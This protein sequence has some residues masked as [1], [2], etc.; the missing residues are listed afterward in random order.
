MS[1]IVDVSITDKG[2]R[3]GSQPKHGPWGGKNADTLSNPQAARV[4]PPTRDIKARPKEITDE[5]DEG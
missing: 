2:R 1:T 4:F 5:S 3:T